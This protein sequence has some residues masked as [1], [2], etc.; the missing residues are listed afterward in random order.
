MADWDKIK[1][2]EIQD[3]IENA[4][5]RASRD[6]D[7]VKWLHEH[8]NDEKIEVRLE[9]LIFDAKRSVLLDMHHKILEKI[10]TLN[11]EIE[12]CKIKLATKAD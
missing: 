5:E 10:D 4:K 1:A 3:S 9:A 8:K 11:D 7:I 12:L 6:V 2:R